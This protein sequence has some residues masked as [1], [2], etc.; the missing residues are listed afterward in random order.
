MI[1]EKCIKPHR[2]ARIALIDHGV[3]RRP[4]RFVSYIMDNTN[5]STQPRIVTRP[6]HRDPDYWRVRELLIETYSI[7]PTD[8]NWE[9]RRWDGWH[10]HRTQTDWKPGWEQRFCLWETCLLYT[11]DA[12]DE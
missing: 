8:F 9:I 4:V 10:T 5:P 3:M 2:S 1:A 7:T 11:S 12:A 6:Y